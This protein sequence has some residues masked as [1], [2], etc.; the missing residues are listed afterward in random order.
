VKLPGR[1]VRERV[2]GTAAGC[3]SDCGAGRQ[4][5]ER[6]WC[7]QLLSITGDPAFGQVGEEAV[8]VA[9]EREEILQAIG[10]FGGKL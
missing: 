1:V 3:H 4:L 6:T 7:V 8:G 2:A 10:D 9:F 5:E